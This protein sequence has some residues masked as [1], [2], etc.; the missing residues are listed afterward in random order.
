MASFNVNGNAQANGDHGAHNGGRSCLSGQESSFYFV[1]FGNRRPHELKRWAGLAL[2]LFF[3]VSLVAV[4]LGD[5]LGHSGGTNS[6]G[7]HHN[8]KTGGY[9]CH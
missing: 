8:H 9:H 2:V 7:C 5:T 1:K 6:E 3:V 4:P